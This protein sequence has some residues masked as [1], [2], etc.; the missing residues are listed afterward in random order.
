MTRI[1]V[2]KWI[3]EGSASPHGKRH[4]LG[5]S[6]SLHVKGNS[7]LWIFKFRDANKRFTS[8][9]LGPA[10]GPQK[11]DPSEALAAA[12]RIRAQLKAGAAIATRTVG[13]GET[14][15]DMLALYVNKK[16]QEW[17]AG[18]DEA[19]A[20]ARLL[21][22]APAFGK[23]A[24]TSISGADIVAALKPWADKPVA[25]IKHMKRVS[26]VFK[27]AMLLGHAT[28][29][30]ASVKLLPKPENEEH[31]PALPWQSLPAFFAKLRA[32]GSPAA[33]A[34]AFTI[35]TA[36]RVGKV[37]S[38][39]WGQIKGGVWNVEGNRVKNAMPVPLTP[40]MLALIGERGAD[41]AP[42]FAGLNKHSFDGMLD[43]LP[44]DVPGR[45]PVPHGFRS[46]FRGWARANKKDSEVA[47][48][49]LG[50]TIGSRTTRAYDRVGETM[51]L[52]RELLTSWS[53][54]AL[55]G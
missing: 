28:A 47:E 46:T 41:D 15:A 26:A 50:H 14:F 12:G 27:H 10:V 4:T 16:Q 43:G 11:L 6:V 7:A 53:D 18:S 55:A 44:S 25:A 21:R 35:L 45:L 17:S 49:V 2:A 31:H 5:Q 39:T 51:E 9:M 40:A 52:R 32:V 48:M 30:P 20:Y 23:L 37:K 1:N 24:I 42:L 38:A 3:R 19:E 13:S 22:D 36:A 29:N 33:R 34:L 8:R 54:F